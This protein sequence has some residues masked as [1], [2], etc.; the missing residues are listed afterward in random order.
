M[1]SLS[2]YS[3]VGNLNGTSPLA[4]SMYNGALILSLIAMI[5]YYWYCYNKKP[6]IFRELLKIDK[7]YT[8]IFI[9]FIVGLISARTAVR[10]LFFFAPIT[11]V[12]AAYIFTHVYEWA[13][14]QQKAA[15]IITLITMGIFLFSI[16]GGFSATVIAQGQGVG[17]AYNYQWQKA[18]DWTNKNTPEDAVFAHWWDYGYYVQTGANRATISDG[19]NA[20][21]A[22]N[23][24]TGR[25]FLTA[26]NYT[27][28]L[29]FL[30]ANGVTH[31][32]IISEEIGKYGAF[33]SIGSDANYDR[34]SWINM[35]QLDPQKTMETRNTTVFGYFGAWGLDEDMTYQGITFP[36]Q[37]AAIAAFFVPVQTTKDQEGN[38]VFGDIETPLAVT[39]YNNQRYDIPVDCIFIQGQDIKTFNIK[40]GHK[41]CLYVMPQFITDTQ[42]NPIG[43]T[44]YLSPRVRASRL[45]HL[46]L[47]GEETENFKLIYSDE[48]EFPLSIYQGRLI[49]PLKI[50]QVT[51]P[52][53]I[54][55]NP[56]YRNQQLPDPRV[57][58][59]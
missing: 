16:I 4:T 53:D 33:S 20:R 14:V 26:P 46:Y 37:Q 8:F 51:Y 42:V 24:F 18:M 47:F 17:A 41:G 45:A 34:L 36:K 21:G 44:M 2:R 31:T 58:Q 35:F 40:E 48:S 25:Y 19:G 22:I 9:W 56:V 30:Y 15:K 55:D 27:D 7:K 3:D 57:E 13:K 29:D 49:G 54:K 23:Y 59:V 1:F 10:M 32:L 11:A 39:I 50:W 38:T 12:V 52:K 43:A 5:G 6:E 28:A